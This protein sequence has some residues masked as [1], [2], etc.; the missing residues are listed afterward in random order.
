MAE[1]DGPKLHIDDDWK[2]EAQRE[3]ERLAKKAAA[4]SA[5]AGA[6]AAASPAASASAGMDPRAAMAGMAGQ[7][8]S[9]GQGEDGEAL[10]E[11]S[12]QTLVSM[13]A[14]QA[15]LYMGAIPD[16][17]SGRRIAMFDMARHNIDLLEVI[18]AKTAGNLDDEEKSLI[19]STLYE[20]RSH[21]VDA[22][23][24]SLVTAQAAAMSERAGARQS[25]GGIVR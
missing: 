3:K 24:S 8:G 14:S 13:L 9:T 2:K 15:L 16:P 1:Q 19:G 10:P 6:A 7:A 12:F 21:Y 5:G 22:V 11:A 17:Q 23:S 25:G 4:A 20:L 18:E